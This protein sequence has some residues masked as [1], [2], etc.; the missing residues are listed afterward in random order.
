MNKFYVAAVELQ[1]END[2]G[3]I[4]KKTERYLVEA[5]SVT[6]AEAIVTKS[7]EGYTFDWIVKGVTESNIVEVLKSE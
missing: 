1:F 5:V 2:K 3:G 6:D 7:Y 4:S